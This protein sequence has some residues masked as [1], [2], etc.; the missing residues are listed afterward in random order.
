MSLIRRR[1]LLAASQTG[2]VGKIENYLRK[3]KTSITKQVLTLDFP[4]ETSLNV[5][6]T[7]SRSIS[8]TSIL[9]KGSNTLSIGLGMGESVVSVDRIDPSED[10][11]YIYKI[12]YK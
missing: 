10:D 11:V 2:G 6:Y 3:G 12:D 1:A 7:D 4:A 8:R 5:Y 9:Q